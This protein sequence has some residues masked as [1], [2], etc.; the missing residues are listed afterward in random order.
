MLLLRSLFTL[1][2]LTAAT[3]YAL[4]AQAKSDSIPSSLVSDLRLNF[5]AMAQNGRSWVNSMKKDYVPIAADA[6]E[7]SS[8]EAPVVEAASKVLFA[9]S[10]FSG[11]SPLR[12]EEVPR[13]AALFVVS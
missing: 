3:S 8:V 9:G 1:C 11:I 4:Q 6:I 13:N 2:L 12:T 10:Y 7:K 5:S